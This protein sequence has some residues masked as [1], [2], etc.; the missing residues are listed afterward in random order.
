METCRTPESYEGGGTDFMLIGGSAKQLEYRQR[1]LAEGRQ[2]AR[3]AIDYANNNWNDQLIYDNAKGFG[4][5]SIQDPLDLHINGLPRTIKKIFFTINRPSIDIAVESHEKEIPLSELYNNSI[6]EITANKAVWNE[7][8]TA[9]LDPRNKIDR[10]KCEGC[11][12]GLTLNS[13]PEEGLYFNPHG[14]DQFEPRH[15]L[16]PISKKLEDYLARGGFKFRRD[17]GVLRAKEGRQEGQFK[18]QQLKL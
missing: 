13:C 3:R 16:S 5:Y 2:S 7:L 11:G 17:V 6:V 8:Y 18:R 14:L 1:I 12:G 15:D 10:V 9:V 4:E